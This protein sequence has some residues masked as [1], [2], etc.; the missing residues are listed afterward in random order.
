MAEAGRL[1]VPVLYLYTVPNEKFY[2]SLGW[3]FQQRST[4]REENIAIM[5]CHPAT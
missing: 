1:S 2:A 5:T 4:Y 3:S